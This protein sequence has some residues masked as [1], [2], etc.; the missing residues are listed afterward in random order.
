MSLYTSRS[1]FDLEKRV[2]FTN[3]IPPYDMFGGLNSVLQTDLW[4]WILGFTDV[5]FGLP[6]SIDTEV[7][8]YKGKRIEKSH[9]AGID[10]GEVYYKMVNG[11]V[12]ERACSYVA[13]FVYY[14]NGQIVVEDTKGVRTKEYTIKRKLMLQKWGIQITEV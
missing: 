8:D 2:Q 1:E 7:E 4:K 10:S 14:K 6:Y 3:E 9:D 5:E 11:K 13:D 12:V